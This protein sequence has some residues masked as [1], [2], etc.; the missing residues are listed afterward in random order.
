MRHIFNTK[1]TTASFG[2]SSARGKGTISCVS[3]H[4]VDNLELCNI[5]D[6][7]HC[8][9]YNILHDKK[10]LSVMLFNAF[11]AKRRAR[12]TTK[13]QYRIPPRMPTPGFLYLHSSNGLWSRK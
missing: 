10:E 5:N 6:S 12:L 2:C 13:C 1:V 9:P 7:I 3:T 11:E 4:W 8:N